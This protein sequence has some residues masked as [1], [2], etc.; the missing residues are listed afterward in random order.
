MKYGRKP[1]KKSNIRSRSNLAGDG[2]DA[3]QDRSTGS[4]RKL[5]KEAS[6]KS[7]QIEVIHSNLPNGHAHKFETTAATPKP[8]ADVPYS[9]SYVP[10]DILFY[11]TRPVTVDWEANL[12]AAV[13]CYSAAINAFS[14]LSEC[15]ENVESTMR[16]KGWTCNELGRKRLAHGLVKSAEVSFALAIESF[17]E[18]KDLTN[19]VL[20]HCNLGHGRRAAAEAVAAKLPPEDDCDYLT[21]FVQTIAEAKFLYG[22]ALKYYGLARREVNGGN[23]EAM[24][25]LWNEVHTQLAHTYLRLGMLLAREDRFVYACRKNKEARGLVGDEDVTDRNSD[26]KDGTSTKDAITKALILYE[27]LGK[28]RAQE[29]AFA[30]FQLAGHHRDSC[31]S[32]ANQVDAF[33]SKKIETSMFQ[34]VKLHA[35]LAELYWQKSLD[36][37]KPETHVDMFLGILMERSALCSEMAASLNQNLMIEQALTYLLEGRRAFNLSDGGE[38][39]DIAAHQGTQRERPSEVIVAKFILQIQKLL[40]TMLSAALMLT[41]P[42]PTAFAVNRARRNPDSANN[43]EPSAAKTCDIVKLKEMY[44]ASLQLQGEPNLEQLYK[45]WVS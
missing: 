45:L 11:L 23:G 15:S 34:K 6:S 13:D 29:A 38:G 22:E 5:K 7:R 37:Y 40:K 14:G 3:H 9:S 1:T 32:A 21:P 30:Q 19:I 26:S 43:G 25:G 35:S 31:V 41:K 33:G 24:S 12:S 42:S 44:R 36:F 20:V 18:V 2:A 39:G 28:F 8:K 16:K 17:R 4:E 10:P 27:S